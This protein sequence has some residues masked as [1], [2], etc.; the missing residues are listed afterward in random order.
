MQRPSDDFAHP[1]AKTAGCFLAILVLPGALFVCG[2]ASA[3]IPVF[4]LGCC[5]ITTLAGLSALCGR[6][7]VVCSAIRTIGQLA[8][9]WR[10]RP[11]K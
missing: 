1:V 8:E 11:M 10:R 6:P 3:P 5:S 4:A 9:V 7:S 2:T